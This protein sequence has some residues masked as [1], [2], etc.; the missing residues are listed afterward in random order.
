MV[1]A[2]LTQLFDRYRRK[3]AKS[4]S[5]VIVKLGG[6]HT[7]G[8]CSRNRRRRDSGEPR[9]GIARERDAYLFRDFVQ[10][11]I[12]FKRKFY[13]LDRFSRIIRRA[14][15]CAMILSQMCQSASS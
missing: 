10:I 12:H 11:Y 2:A 5:Q 3:P 6:S 15:E 14:A 9:L 1:K 4:L 8:H 7:C 13:S